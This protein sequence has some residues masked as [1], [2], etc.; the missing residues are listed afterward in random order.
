MM[1][2]WPKGCVVERMAFWMQATSPAPGNV[3][4]NL[5]YFPAGIDGVTWD[6]NDTPPAAP[7]TV[8]C[9]AVGGVAINFNGFDSDPDSTTWNALAGVVMPGDTWL[10]EEILA[11]NPGAFSYVV[12]LACIVWVPKGRIRGFDAAL[13]FVPTQISAS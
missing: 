7:E 5:N 12:R 13:E 1:L 8:I 6:K 9:A 4:I 11:A 3:S 2:T 10:F